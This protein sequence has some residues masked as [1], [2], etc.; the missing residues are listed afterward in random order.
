MNKNVKADFVLVLVTMAWGLSYLLIDLSLEEM[1]NFTLNALRFGGAFLCISIFAFPK[2][3]HI[4]KA[5]FRYSALIGIILLGVYTTATYGVQYTSISNSGF[6]ISLTVLFTPIFSFFIK[7][8]VLEK[9]I[10]LVCIACTAGV[11]LM[12]LDENFRIAPGDMICL[13][14]A[15][16]NSL[17]LITVEI[18]VRKEDVDAFQCAVL[19][20]GFM[21]VYCTILAFL[22]EEPT[23]PQSTTV[24]ASVIF[25]SLVCTGF[26]LIAQSI[27]QKYTDAS[28]VGVIYTLEPVFASFIA[29]VWAG[30]VLMPRAYLGEAIMICSMIIMEIDLKRWLPAK[31]GFR[32]KIKI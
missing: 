16:L 26:A 28:H 7:K 6:L 4:S 10:F 9:K 18:A 5:T 23:L 12:T 31:I 11:A 29:M 13:L 20:M 27:V 25:L 21:G 14:C 22:L 8:Q 30:E 19:P 32:S 2:L 15:V 1:G 3:K 17:Y 24:W